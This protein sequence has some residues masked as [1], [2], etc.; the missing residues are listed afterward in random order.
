M[1]VIRSLDKPGAFTILVNK[2]GTNRP[3]PLTEVSESNFDVV[4]DLNVKSAFFVA[5]IVVQGMIKAGW[6][7]SVIN[8][9]SP[10]GPVGGPWRRCSQILVRWNF[11]N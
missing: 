6:G 7:G 5:Q 2:A 10:I 1:N 8:M 3:E 9:S 11:Q 4:M